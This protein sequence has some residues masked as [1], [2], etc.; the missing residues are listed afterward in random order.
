MQVTFLGASNKFAICNE[1]KAVNSKHNVDFTCLEP[2]HFE[3]EVV[4]TFPYERL[5]HAVLAWLQ[6]DPQRCDVLHGHEWGGAFVDVITALHFR[7]V[8]ASYE[9]AMQLSPA[10]HAL[11]DRKVPTRRGRMLLGMLSALLVRRIA[12]AASHTDRAF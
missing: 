8:Q 4:E 6:E 7:Q 11:H 2:K 1:A 5:S 12:S 10:L 9:C 3:P